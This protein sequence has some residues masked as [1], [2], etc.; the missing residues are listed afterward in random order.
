MPPQV[1]GPGPRKGPV[2]VH[3]QDGVNEPKSGNLQKKSVNEQNATNSSEPHRATAK[4]KSQ[5]N[6]E[7]SMELSSWLNKIGDVISDALPGKSEE[8]STEA[9]KTQG[10]KAQGGWLT[11]L[12]KTLGELE[13]KQAEKI[14]AKVSKGVKS[15]AD[16]ADLN[17]ESQIGSAMS[18]ARN[19][20][21]KSIGE[22]VSTAARKQ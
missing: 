14:K 10:G 13:N 4:E 7:K 8:N 18:E 12:A 15:Q 6:L 2:V 16:A 21:I 20:V 19:T 11:D 3:S 9:K 1:S 5:K 17:A 22:A